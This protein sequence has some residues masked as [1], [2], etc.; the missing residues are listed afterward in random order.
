MG[1]WAFT[2]VEVV[3]VFA[4]LLVPDTI[5]IAELAPARDCFDQNVVPSE[6]VGY[7]F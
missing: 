2:T 3:H 6:D 4:V 7:N 5:A 1:P